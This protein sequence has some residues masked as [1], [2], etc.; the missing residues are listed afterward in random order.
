MSLSKFASQSQIIEDLIVGHITENAHLY[1]PSP[2][3]LDE[4]QPRFKSPKS[5]YWNTTWGRLLMD[6]DVQDPKSRAGKIFRL[7]FRLP[8]Y[9]DFNFLMPSS[10]FDG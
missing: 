7:Q 5:S 2:P 10:R 4:I 3:I 6:P 9:L 8:W 1:L